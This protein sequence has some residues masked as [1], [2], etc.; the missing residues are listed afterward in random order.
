MPYRPVSHVYGDRIGRVRW[1]LLAVMIGLTMSC[2]MV[3]VCC[4]L[5]S[6]RSYFRGHHHRWSRS[7]PCFVSKSFRYGC[8][9]QGQGSG[10][11]WNKSGFIV[12]NMH[13]ITG[14]DALQVTLHDQSTWPARVVGVTPEIDLA[15]LHIQAPTNALKAVE[16]GSRHASSRS[17]SPCDW[18]PI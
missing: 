18:K 3:I 11:V 14:A 12:T 1:S 16:L 10:F 7:R 5:R 13:V 17:E 2:Q 8:F 4:P 6:K 9:P 15:V